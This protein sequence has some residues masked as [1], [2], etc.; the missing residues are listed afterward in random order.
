MKKQQNNSYALDEYEKEVLQGLER[1][2]YKSFLGVKSEREKYR[3][4]AKAD[5]EKR[6]NIN[7]RISEADLLRMKARAA[8]KGIP[9]QTMITS[10]I[11]QYSTG[12]IKD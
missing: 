5:L 8:Q 11:H 4:M 1:E 9:Y 12:Q 7:I 6:R 2:G 10:V 3:V